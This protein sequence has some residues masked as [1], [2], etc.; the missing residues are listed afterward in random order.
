MKRVGIQECTKTTMHSMAISMTD[1]YV[2]NANAGFRNWGFY[3]I[4]QNKRIIWGLFC[5]EKKLKKKN[6]YV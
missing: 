3:F 2:S 4:F 5:F 1:S 6:V